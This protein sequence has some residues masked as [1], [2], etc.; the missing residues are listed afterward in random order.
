MA[1]FS[2]VISSDTCLW[3]PKTLLNSRRLGLTLYNPGLTLPRGEQL[4]IGNDQS[5]WTVQ[6]FLILGGLVFRKKKRKNGFA[7]TPRVFLLQS[8]YWNT[9]SLQFCRWLSIAIPLLKSQLFWCYRLFYIPTY[10]NIWNHVFLSVTSHHN[11]HHVRTCFLLGLKVSG[12]CH[13]RASFWIKSS[14][15][16]VDDITITGWWFQTCFIFHNILE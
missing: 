5:R 8:D 2:I 4:M 11:I 3:Y 14:R 7:R 13:H 9:V 15:I 1:T 10:W 16:R 12:T 6:D